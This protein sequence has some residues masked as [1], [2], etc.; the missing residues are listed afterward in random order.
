MRPNL[1]P[2]PRFYRYWE[3]Q[4]N[5]ANRQKSKKFRKEKSQSQNYHK[6]R[7]RYA[8]KHLKVS[9]QREEF[10]KRLNKS[11]ILMKL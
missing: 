4:L 2:N 5:R 7:Q 10:V 8:L 11:T 6:A 9:R 3:R 1:E